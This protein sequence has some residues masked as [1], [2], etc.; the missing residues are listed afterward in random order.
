ML[1]L[2]AE[3]LWLRIGFQTR[4]DS[5]PQFQLR[6]HLKPAGEKVLPTF[7]PH[8][9]SLFLVRSRL[10]IPIEI[11]T[12]RFSTCWDGGWQ[13][14]G[15]W[16]V[17]ERALDT[18]IQIVTPEN[19]AFDYRVAGPL[20]RLLA[21]LLD[22]LFRTGIVFVVYMAAMLLIVLFAFL[23]VYLPFLRWFVDIFAAFSFTFAIVLWFLLDWFYGGFFESYWNGQTPGKR[24]FGLRVVTIDGRPINGL[25][26]VLRNVLR[27]VDLFPFLSIEMFGPLFGLNDP[28][29]PLYV[30]PTLLFGIISMLL[31]RRFQRIGDLVCGTMVVLEERYW[32]AG[33][34]KLEDERVPKLAT[35]LPAD[36]IVHRSL[37]KTLSLYAERRL[38]L[39]PERRQ[40]LA[41]KLGK[42]YIQRFNLLPDTS[43]DLLLCAMYYRAFVAD[44]ARQSQDSEG[45]SPL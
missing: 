7:L 3:T 40:E 25:Q 38:N 17:M 2:G 45:K 21:L 22:Y 39:Q 26:A 4:N 13:D 41:S 23:S 28:L 37:A 8:R 33:I 18:T 42:P 19:I 16:V 32:L 1:A 12:S 30:I 20:N 9:A 29:P 36:F 6:N 35:L 31:T 44:Q 43:C 5:C 27:Y 34:A 15:K 11:K 24:V 14:R 10:I